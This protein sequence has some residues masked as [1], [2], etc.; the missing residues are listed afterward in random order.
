MMDD[1]PS[2]LYYSLIKLNEN[3]LPTEKKEYINDSYS[4]TNN[5]LLNL[6]S[7]KYN[8]TYHVV[9]VSSYSF[10]IFSD[11]ELE[12]DYYSSSNNSD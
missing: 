2:Q 6:Q 9:G 11:R 5:N 12:S 1:V 4:V 3:L 10:D 8:E 7:S